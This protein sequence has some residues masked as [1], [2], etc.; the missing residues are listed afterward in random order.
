RVYEQETGDTSISDRIL[1][2]KIL[3][4][5]MIMRHSFDAV[6]LGKDPERNNAR[7]H[8][9]RNFLVYSMNDFS[10]SLAGAA[11]PSG[12]TDS[13][14]FLDLDGVFDQE[15]LGFPHATQS[16]LQSL[17]LLR[18]GGFSVVINTG[19]SVQHVRQYCDAYGL[20]GGIGEFGSVFIDA[21]QGREMPLIDNT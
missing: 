4:G 2:H 13:L 19:R 14:F 16:A 12:W 9:A 15:L 8:E 3:Y 17:A 18:S 11:R 21:I 7:H 5:T 1:L 10:A 20:P 6:A